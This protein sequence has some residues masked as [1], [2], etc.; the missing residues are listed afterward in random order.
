MWVVPPRPSICRRRLIFERSLFDS[1]ILPFYASAFCSVVPSSAV[2]RIEG[3]RC[4]RAYDG[5]L[6]TCTGA[7]ELGF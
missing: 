4:L 6:K 2:Q 5:N 1:L 7:G 3:E